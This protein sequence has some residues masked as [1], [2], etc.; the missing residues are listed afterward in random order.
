MALVCLQLQSWLQPTPTILPH[1][2]CNCTAIW[3]TRSPM[4]QPHTSHSLRIRCIPPLDTSNLHPR[5]TPAQPPPP[6]PP[7]Q[8]P[9]PPQDAHGHHQHLPNLQP[10][11]PLATV[12]QQ[13]T[14]PTTPGP[15]PTELSAL[16]A[17]LEPAQQHIAA[18]ASRLEHLP[19]LEAALAASRAEHKALT[20]SAKQRTDRH[21]KPPGRRAT[22]ITISTTVP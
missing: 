15:Q 9:P 22:T 16:H 6:P 17:Q 13:K 14:R 8:R 5:V 4:D 10:T 19:Q 21:E 11:Q 20:A 1:S 7:P 3:S 18:Q 12:P 2:A